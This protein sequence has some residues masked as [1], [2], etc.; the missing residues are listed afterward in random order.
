MIINANLTSAKEFLATLT[1]HSEKQVF[2][3]CRT[4]NEPDQKSDATSEDQL[5]MISN[6]GF[7][8]KISFIIK[9]IQESLFLLAPQIAHFWLSGP[10]S[11]TQG[12]RGCP[13]W[14]ALKPVFIGEHFEPI[15]S[16]GQ[17]ILLVLAF[18]DMRHQLSKASTRQRNF[19]NQSINGWDRQGGFRSPPPNLEGPLRRQTY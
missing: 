9:I 12:G 4:R 3:A 17:K 16:W 13:S 14:I 18:V 1:D 5:F 8:S 19:E 6:F 15:K 7:W 2:W 10:P 11:P